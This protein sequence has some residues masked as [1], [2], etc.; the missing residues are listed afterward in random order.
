MFFAYWWGCNWHFF[1]SVKF[2]IECGMFE[3]NFVR[4]DDVI[5]IL[6]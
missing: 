6:K 5:C 2:S 3:G 4:I 1:M